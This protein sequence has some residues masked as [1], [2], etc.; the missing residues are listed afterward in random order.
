MKW[1]SILGRIVKDYPVTLF[2]AW[3][4]YKQVYA[5]DPNGYLALIGFGCMFP[6]ARAA[7]ST[8]WSTPG[9]SSSSPPPEQEPRSVSSR[10]EG[11]DERKV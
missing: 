4:I 7:I 11:T 5:T 1:D 8:I 10:P 6:A 2:G 9:S 3:I